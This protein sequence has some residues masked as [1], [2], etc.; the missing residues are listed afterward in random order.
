MS[1]CDNRK[2][3]REKKACKGENELSLIHILTM[4][5]NVSAKIV[6]V[7]KDGETEIP[8]PA[9]FGTLSLSGR[10]EDAAYFTFESFAFPPVLLRFDGERMELSLIHISIWI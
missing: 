9:K 1:V 4:M 3:G 2:G 6:C 10:T 8:L 5:D 7:E